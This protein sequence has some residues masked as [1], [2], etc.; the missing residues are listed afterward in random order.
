[1]VYSYH[2]IRADRGL[3]NDNKMSDYPYILAVTTTCLA[4][5]FGDVEDQRCLV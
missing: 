4:G 2:T 3:G 1:M 5:V